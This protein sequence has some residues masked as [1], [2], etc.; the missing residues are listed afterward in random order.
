MKGLILSIIISINLHTTLNGQISKG[1]WLVS[2][3]SNANTSHITKNVDFIET[4]FKNSFSAGRFLSEHII[5]GTELQHLI[6]ETY[7]VDSGVLGLPSGKYS[8]S[9]LNAGLY[10]RNYFGEAK[11]KWRLLAHL[12]LDYNREKF[13]SKVFPLFNRSLSEFVCNGGIGLIKRINRAFYFET[14]VTVPIFEWIQRDNNEFNFRWYKAPP[15]LINAGLQVLL[16]KF[17]F[18]KK[19]EAPSINKNKKFTTWVFQKSD[20][21]NTLSM[22]PKFGWFASDKI[23]AGASILFSINIKEDLKWASFGTGPF[24]RYYFHAGNRFGFFPEVSYVFSASENF[25]AI[26]VANRNSTSIFHDIQLGVGINYFI[27]ENIA[28][29]CSTNKNISWANFENSNKFKPRD[30]KLFSLDIGL[31]FFFEKN[32]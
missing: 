9:N 5:V 15:A 20:A 10:I 6:T 4:K 31:L 26:Q 13:D 14:I 12:Q 8:V 27:N 11:Q 18:T 3:K 17:T 22:K 7:Y 19:F 21:P 23:A 30:R 1:D 25:Y 2:L 28:L 24:V 29:E 16:N 32:K